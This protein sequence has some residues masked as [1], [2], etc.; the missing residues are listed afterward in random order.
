VNVI[1]QND[2]LH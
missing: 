2:R 1:G